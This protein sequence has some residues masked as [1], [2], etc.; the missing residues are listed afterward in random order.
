MAIS[1]GDAILKLG[2]DKTSFDASMAETERNVKSAMERI[3]GPLRVA[4]AAFTAF[5]GIGL[6]MVGDARQLNAQLGQTAL[7][8]GL[9]AS[10]MR[11]LALAT[12]DVT[13]PLESVAKTFEMLARAGVRGKAEMQAT[14]KAFDTLADATGSSAE[15]LAEMLIPAY[16]AFGLR[17]PTT[18]ADMDKFTWLTKNTTV[19]LSDFATV[20]QRL[21]PHMQ[22]AGISMDDA[23]IAL[24]ALEERGTTGRRA[25]MEL[26]AAI[27][28]AAKNGTDF[29]TELGLTSGAIDTYKGIMKDATG[30]TQR[31]SDVAA[32][33]FGIMDNLKQ[34]WQELGLRI[35]S[36]LTPMEPLLALMTAL[37]PI[38]LLSTTPAVGKLAAALW[39]MAAASWAALGPIGLIIAA[40]AAL[41]IGAYALTKTFHMEAEALYAANAEGGNYKYTIEELEQQLKEAAEAAATL[42]TVV[43]GTG[44]ATASTIAKLAQLAAIQGIAKN[45]TDAL[46]QSQRN[47][48]AA[49]NAYPTA[50]YQEMAQAAVVATGEA[51]TEIL[52][53]A[54]ANYLQQ[55]LEAKGYP[56][57]FFAG[58]QFG[59]TVP[60]PVGKPQ[61]AVVH[62]GETYTPPGKA[63]YV[64]VQVNVDGERLFEILAERIGKKT[65]QW[66]RVTPIEG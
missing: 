34:M 37:G 60:G 26:S 50:Y 30:L 4:G 7:T 46:T 66:G 8:I 9:S 38:M 20:V 45:T 6:K 24:A 1:L 51:R 25:T 40:A 32:T 63:D 19:N 23:M 36:V 28:R 49:T 58:Y 17:L 2:I 61:L 56:P 22:A 35:G 21:A 47:L 12:T 11:D 42:N 55:T 18:A 64:N 13:F 59:G 62:G 33:Q 53:E 29:R 14:A 41:G 43:Y 27:E 31:M 48:N 44:D 3:Q 16:R 39:G 15:V 10:E 65:Q 52:A 54:Q 57:G 5:G